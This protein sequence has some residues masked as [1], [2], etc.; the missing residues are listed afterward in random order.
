MAFIDKQTGA[1][2]RTAADMPTYDSHLRGEEA[3][4]Y[5]VSLCLSF[6]RVSG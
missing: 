1:R 4:A 2:I 6:A 3:R 5:M